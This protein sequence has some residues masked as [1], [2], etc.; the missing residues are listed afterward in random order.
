MRTRWIRL[1]VAWIILGHLVTWSPGHL[2]PEARAEDV[3]DSP[4]YRSPDLPAPPVELLFH[5]E[6]KALW[7]KALARPEADL[8]RQA[9]EAVSLAQRRGVKGLDDAVAPLLAEL[10]RTDQHPAVRLA[11]AEALASL[12]ARDAAPA[13]LRLART[14]DLDLRDLVEP[15][16][17]RWDYRPAR[18]VWLGRLR[19]PAAS[20]RGLVLAARGLATVGEADATDRLREL[21]LSDRAAPPV[22]L[23]AAG[24][25]GRLRTEGLEKDADRLAADPSPRAIP[26][27]LAAAAL[28]RHHQG[29]EAVRLLGRLAEDRE[30]AVAA[31]AVARLLEIDP[32]LVVPSAERLL[33]SPDANLRSLAVEVL[34]LRPAEKGLRLLADRL[35]DE[36][37]DVRGQARRAL[38]GLAAK[39]ELREPI[40]GEATRLLGGRGWRGLEQAALLLGQ[41]DHKPAAQRLVELLANDRPETFVAAAWALRKLAVKET[42]PDVTKHVEATLKRVWGGKGPLDQ[43][44]PLAMLDHQLAQLNQLLGQQKYEPADAVL[45]QFLPPHPDRPMEEA[46]AAAAWALGLIHEGQPVAALVT[47]LEGR[48]KDMPPGI[49]PEDPRMRRMAAVALGRMKAQDALGSLRS[50]YGGQGPNEDPVSNACGWAVE[51]ITGEVM[52]APKVIHRARLDWFLI[53]NK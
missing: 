14:D 43:A 31:P 32:G 10:D 52:P 51:Q 12:D 36:H 17:A 19:D 5:E 38:L 42:L 41:L 28:L 26:A 4:M 37:P 22:R 47:A 24:A 39:P 29:D 20:P 23:E 34:H 13:F 53:P 35:D 3:I 25:L 40:L 50:F 9:A 11:V 45:R 18:E 30:P 33:G 7:L 46:R 44:V 2:V 15:A 27:R 6:T 49:P 21:A 16:L 1:A 8:R 48:L